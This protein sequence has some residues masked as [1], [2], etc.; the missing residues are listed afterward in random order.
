MLPEFIRNGRVP[1]IEEHGIYQFSI[2]VELQLGGSSIAEAHRA[3]APIPIQMIEGELRQI[4]FASNTID[5]LQ[6]AVRLRVMSTSIHP[7]HKPFCLLAQTKQ[8]QTIDH[9]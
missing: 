6:S 5:G 9:Q 1:V 8:D 2:H 3:T 4:A 7:A